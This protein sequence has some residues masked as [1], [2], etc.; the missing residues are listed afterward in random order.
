M[1]I[2]IVTYSYH[3]PHTYDTYNQVMAIYMEITMSTQLV[4]GRPNGAQLQ[5]GSWFV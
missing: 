2:S 1:D 3:P 5:E 4:I